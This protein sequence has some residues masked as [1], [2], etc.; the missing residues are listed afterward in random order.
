MT[1]LH[2]IFCATM[3]HSNSEG[4]RPSSF[5]PSAPVQNMVRNVTVFW[6]YMF[7]DL[8]EFQIPPH[9]SHITQYRCATASWSTFEVIFR[10]PCSY[11][12]HDS[13]CHSSSYVPSTY[14]QRYFNR[15]S[16]HSGTVSYETFIT[17]RRNLDV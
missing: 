12:M 4:V 11:C 13:S 9:R 5:L 17:G 8:L 1:T 16:S 3:S 7:P 6:K 14:R 15:C 10:V 2:A